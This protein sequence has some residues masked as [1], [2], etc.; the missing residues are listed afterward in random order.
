MARPRK[1]NGNTPKIPLKQPDR[2]G[3]SQ[4]TLYEMA[5]R[6][7]LW[8]AGDNAKV[9]DVDETAPGEI[10]IGRFP[11]SLLWSFTLTIVH[12]TLDLFV[13]HQY[14]MDVSWTN[15]CWNTAKAFPGEFS[16]SF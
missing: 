11:E 4:E 13:Q 15:M 10:L 8:E 7:G 14:A 12:F 16:I 1:G 9:E 5:M 3:P 6:R 2:A